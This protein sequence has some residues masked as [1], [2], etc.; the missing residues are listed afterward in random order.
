MSEKEENI[1]AKFKEALAKGDVPT[2]RYMLSF[3]ERYDQMARNIK[4]YEQYLA[5][6]YTDKPSFDAYGWID[7]DKVLE[8]AKESESIFQEDRFELIVELCQFPNGKWV[9]GI[10][11]NLSESGHYGGVSI[12][13]TQYPNRHSAYMAALK[14]ALAD[15][16]HSSCKSDFKYIKIIKQKMV[17]ALEPSLF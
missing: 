14:S 11:I 2:I 3:T 17:A 15:V 12:W 10:K 5:C 13:N 7:N 8:K 4:A 9:S 6:G 1:I 16:Q